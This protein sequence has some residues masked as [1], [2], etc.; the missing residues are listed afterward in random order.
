MLFGYK[1]TYFKNGTLGFE[2]LQVTNLAQR[3]NG[4]LID[5]NAKT[6]NASELVVSVRLIALVCCFRVLADL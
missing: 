5:F 4:S 2:E 3:I 6:D 1:T